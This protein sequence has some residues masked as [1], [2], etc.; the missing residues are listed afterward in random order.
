M[1]NRTPAKPAGAI[2]RLSILDESCFRPILRPP[3]LGRPEARIHRVHGEF[4]HVP[5]QAN[6]GRVLRR[7]RPFVLPSA[8]P[9]PGQHHLRARVRNG[10]EQQILPSRRD[11]GDPRK[12]RELPGPGNEKRQDLG[13]LPGASGYTKTQFGTV[14]GNPEQEE[15]GLSGFAFHPDYAV[16][17]KYYV[18]Y[19]SPQ[20]PPRQICY[21]E[22]IAAEDYLHDSGQPGRRL[23]TIDM[24]EEFYD[25]NGGSP[26][27]GPDG[28]LYLGQGDGGWDIIT[29]D[30]YK[31]GQ[32]LEVL[33]GKILRIDV[34]KK[35]PGLE[36]AIPPDNPFVSDANPKV[37]REIWAYGLRNPYRLA[38]DH[39]TQELYA[40]DVGW[41]KYDEVEII[42]KGGN[43]GW[44]LKE[45]PYCLADACNLAIEEPLATM[46]N[47]SGPGMAK[48]V[49]GGQVYRGDPA[50]PF[51]GVYL[52]GD[53]T[54]KKLFALK[55]PASGPA[56]VKEYPVVTP[57][58]PIAFTLDQMN[59]IYM[60]CYSG[61]IYRLEHPLLKPMAMAIRPQA[62]RAPARFSRPLAVFSGNGPL[63]L[64]AGLVGS[65]EAVALDGTRIG[66]LT[67]ARAGGPASFIPQTRGSGYGVAYLRPRPAP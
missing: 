54:V 3:C 51:Y 64:P 9:N 29:P 12:A 7:L 18:K 59:N 42:K 6:A 10:R 5:I 15:W 20:R 22:R 33:H 62:S 61:T 34:N 8:R 4:S 48:S 44:S 27:F 36:Y 45:G 67:R 23:L 46:A 37:R 66:L 21:D 1:E 25:H 32:N 24:P 63:V 26:V 39:A 57:Q 16:N 11:A 55:K 40:G 30:V 52:F 31:N 14:Q 17:R 28:Y 43:Y 19:G 2:R 49:I 58:E 60:V 38:F 13:A 50:S 41:I 47:G 53:Y 65:Y 35:D 56:T